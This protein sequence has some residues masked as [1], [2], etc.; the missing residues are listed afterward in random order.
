MDCREIKREAKRHG[1]RLEKEVLSVAGVYPSAK[2]EIPWRTVHVSE[3]LC[4]EMSPQA[5]AL[6]FIEEA[7][8]SPH[9]ADARRMFGEVPAVGPDPGGST[10]T[11]DVMV[12]LSELPDGQDLEDAGRAISAALKGA[13][14]RVVRGFAHPP[15][16]VMVVP[17]GFW[18]VE[19]LRKTKA[20]ESERFQ[21]QQVAAPFSFLLWWPPER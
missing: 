8:K 4:A 12:L 16:R 11:V 7:D 6:H 21:G 19:A 14:D 2:G 10:L 17:A 1:D 3:A 18:N 9:G 5:I 15:E 13:I 20:P